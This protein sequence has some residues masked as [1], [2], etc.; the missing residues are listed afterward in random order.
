MGAAIDIAVALIRAAVFVASMQAAGAALFLLL[1]RR[2]LSSIDRSIRRLVAC[3][4]AFA[5][6]MI[7]ARSVL[8]PARMAGALAGISDPF[9]ISLFWGSDVSIAQLTRLAGVIVLLGSVRSRQAWSRAIWVLAIALVVGS[10][11]LMGHTRAHTGSAVLGSLLAIHLAGVAFWFGSLLP[12]LLLLRHGTRETLGSAI[13]GFSHLAVW[14]VPVL[15]AAGAAMAWILLGSFDALTTP[16]GMLLLAKLAG[17]TG[18]LALAAVN[19]FR[20][21]PAIV[22]GVPGASTRMRTTILTEIGLMMGVFIATAFMTTL[23]SPN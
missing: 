20:F 13:S 17:F 11:T 2:H 14:L 19:R 8:E 5:A 9:L 6:L 16:Y 18:L 1:F 15:L 22:A 12:L 3:T 21:T 7:A 23:Y 10:F 4:A